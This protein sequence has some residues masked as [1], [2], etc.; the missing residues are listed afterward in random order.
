VVPCR[1]LN[2]LDNAKGAKAT[3]GALC[4]Q[5]CDELPNAEGTGTIYK[6]GTDTCILCA[7]ALLNYETVA[8]FCNQDLERRNYATAIGDYQVHICSWADSKAVFLTK[9]KSPPLRGVLTWLGRP[10]TCTLNGCHFGAK[11]QTIEYKLLASL[12][13]LNV[14]QSLIIFS[15]LAAGLTVCAKASACSCIVAATFAW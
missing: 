13:A 4:M 8:Y 6:A 1:D 14:V 3:D 11:L 2:K 5:C 7:A 9:C 10:T 15:G 12:N